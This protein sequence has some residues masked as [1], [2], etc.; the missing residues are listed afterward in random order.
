[1]LPRVMPDPARPWAADQEMKFRD[2]VIAALLDTPEAAKLPGERLAPPSPTDAGHEFELLR[3]GAFRLD[4]L[5][6]VDD[7]GQW[8]DLLRGTSAGGSAG[9]VFHPRARW[10]D[11]PFVL[12]M[13]PRVVQPVR[14]NFRFTAADDPSATNDADATAAAL[15]PV[16]G[17]IFYNPLDRALALCDRDGRL[18]GEL[19][20]VEESGK[21]L[22]KWEPDAGGG[23]LDEIRNADLRAFARSLVET[24]PTAKTRLHELLELIDGA[25]KRIRPAAA[26][27]DAALFGRP[28]ALVSTRLGL[29]LFGKA[30]TDPREPVEEDRPAGAGDARLDALRVRVL[31]G[32]SHNTEDGL[33][34]YFKAGDFNRLVPAHTPSEAEPPM[35]R[36]SN[37][38]ADPERD[39]VRVGFGAPESLT[40]LMDP[41]GSVQAA[42][43]I[44]PAKT[45]ML[46]Q[47]ELDGTL[48]RMEASFRVGP[49]L[50]QPDRIAL[51]TPVGEKGRWH[52]RGP[53]TGDAAIPIGP[54][55]PRYFGERPVVA[56]DGRLLLL[57]AEEQL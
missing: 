32:Y 39:A 12:A 33:V 6:L 13:P 44:V 5:W 18:T 20:V 24:A 48:A 8:A 50:M 49:V 43:G 54:S 40:L 17:W 37:Y 21:H 23:A 10:H 16:C 53:L 45:I 3:A 4:E 34:G 55:D 52:F 26:R 38:I 29:E 36:S 57:T 14:L 30:W 7:F 1:M 51:P 15:A 28:L 42:V 9:Q 35:A 46:A 22:V 2:D 41:W 31:L 47:S 19:V 56:A 11:D 27:R 25:L